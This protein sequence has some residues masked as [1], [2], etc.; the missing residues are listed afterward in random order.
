MDENFLIGWEDLQCS[1]NINC[2]Y[3]YVCNVI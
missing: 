3:V 2:I 1:F